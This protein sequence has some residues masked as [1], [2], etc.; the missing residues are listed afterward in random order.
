MPITYNG[1]AIIPA[2]LVSITKTYT[3]AGD[4]TKIGTLFNIVVT[5]SLVA[6]KGS[7]ALDRTFWSSS[8][9]PADDTATMSD[10]TARL[11]AILAKQEAL[12]QLFSEDGKSFEIVPINGINPMKCNPRVESI[13]FGEGT[14]YNICEYTITLEADVLYIS[15]GE[16]GG[17]DSELTTFITSASETWD[18]TFNEELNTFNVSHSVTATGKKHYDQV[19]TA[20]EAWENAKD[21]VTPKLGSGALSTYISDSNL[22]LSGKSGFNHILSENI[23]KYAG[24]YTCTETWILA[25]T[26]ALAT[27]D[28]TVSVETS[29]Q[30]PRKTVSVQGTITGLFSEYTNTGVK[31]TNAQNYF[32]TLDLYSRAMTYAGAGVTLN[33]SVLSSSKGSNPIAGTI[34]YNYSYDD[35]PSLILG[36][37]VVWENITVTENNQGEIIAIVPVIGRTTGPILQN[38]NARTEKSRTLSMEVHVAGAQTILG[39]PSVQAIIDLVAPTGTKVFKV[40]DSDSWNYVAGVFTRDITW[41]YE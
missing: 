26:G 31:I 32:A 19:G 21:F 35:R 38:M 17:E 2:P 24:T 10:D 28:Y 40:T 18:I 39:K 37:D 34:T 12:R 23:D 3:R 15:G 20:T 33:P 14:W 11:Q 29:A 36:G 30:A 22:S 1:S 6:W 41:V 25:N 13:Q 8:G 27:E 5:G 9:Y 4:G 7:P 16:V